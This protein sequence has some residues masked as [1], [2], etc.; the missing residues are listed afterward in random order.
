MIDAEKKILEAFVSKAFKLDPEAVAGLYNE[1][2]ELSDL[3]KLEEADTARIKKLTDNSKNQHGRGLKEGASKVED[4][5][6]NKYAIDSELTGV[7]LF[8]HILLTKVDEAKV[9]TTEDVTKHPDFIR[10]TL[11]FEKKLKAKDKE[12][13]DKF[14]AKEVEIAT[15]T[16]K[17]KVK[18]LALDELTALNPILPEDVAKA[19]KW[20]EK[21]VEEVLKSDYSEQE[22][23]I[24]PIKEGEPL[25]N[26]HGYSVDF[27]SHV[28]T[29]AAGLFDFKVSSDKS[30]SGNKQTD[31][32]TNFVA[33][34]TKDEFND[35]IAKVKTP[36]ERIALL[37]SAR[38]KGLLT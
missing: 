14:K 36:E 32:S 7:E 21:Y 10:A 1:A 23:G 19:Q 34:K 35:R 20:K 27:T 3:S 38:E 6:K 15:A 37:K 29:I 5:L 18:Q 16:L 8:D 25:K 12:V 26:E 33:P 28:K 17:S 31:G 9:G 2:G 24:F 13:E 22:Q 30:S 4:E 11:D